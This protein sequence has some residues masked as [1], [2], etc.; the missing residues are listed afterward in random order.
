MLL[1]KKSLCR[2]PALKGWRVMPISLKVEYPNKLKFFF[3]DLFFIYLA[4]H[5]CQSSTQ[6]FH[7]LGYNPTLHYFVA[8][9]IPALAIRNSFGWLLCPLT[10]SHYCLCFQITSLPG[11]LRCSRHLILLLFSALVLD[12][13]VSLRSPGSFLM[14]PRTQH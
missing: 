9:M 7:R 3:M 2:E 13:A 1:D 8:Q 5:L 12:L 10:Y 6:V 4:I 11:S 14:K